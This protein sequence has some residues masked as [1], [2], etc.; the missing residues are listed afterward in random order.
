MKDELTTSGDQELA[1]WVRGEQNRELF[2]FMLD[3][4]LKKN[5]GSASSRRQDDMAELLHTSRQTL[6]KWRTGKPPA[7][8]EALFRKLPLLRE[9]LTGLRA[10]PSDRP[11][12]TGECRA[13]WQEAAQDELNVL[14]DDDNWAWVLPWDGLR[15]DRVTLTYDSNCKTY[16][17][18]IPSSAEDAL[19]RWENKHADK[20]EQLRNDKTEGWGRQVRLEGVTRTASHGE[21]DHFAIRL[22]PSRFRYYAAIQAR[23]FERETELLE[24]RNE[25][26]ENAVRGLLLDKQLLLPSV[27]ALNIAAVSCDKKTVLRK[28]PKDSPMYAGAWECTVGEMMHGPAYQG[29]EY[30]HFD[31]LTPR[32]DLFLKNAIAEEL[33][34]GR[35]KPDEF[36][37][38]GFVAEYFTLAPKLFAVFTSKAA[39]EELY[40]GAKSKQRT[41]RAQ[42]A[43]LVDLSPEAVIEAIERYQPWAPTSQLGLIF[44]LLS[45]E[46]S[47]REKD[48]LKT[49]LRHLL[50]ARTRGPV[51]PTNARA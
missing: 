35:A 47:N 42:D 28:R 8:L 11:A 39:G 36:L 2:G 33:G 48:R 1:N 49:R 50:P 44:G 32:L 20:A 46:T 27:F 18:F 43:A 21:L 40:R 26:F 25:C 51:A 30:P 5:M 4:C 22:S 41:D 17:N 29:K 34:Y 9:E 6:H 12:E 14:L 37:L 16:D 24:L 23:L 15:P 7:D 3:V 38:Y 45:T 10:I 13:M 31:G 19:K